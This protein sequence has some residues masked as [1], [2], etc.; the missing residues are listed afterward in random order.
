MSRTGPKY[1]PKLINKL[2][3]VKKKYPVLRESRKFTLLPTPVAQRPSASGRPIW[4]SIV[5]R[6]KLPRELSGLILSKPT[7]ER[8]FVLLVVVVV[9]Y[10]Y[11]SQKIGIM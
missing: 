8:L 9:V 10:E 5:V 7:V 3:Y 2:Y 11:L 6:R 1:D 4:T